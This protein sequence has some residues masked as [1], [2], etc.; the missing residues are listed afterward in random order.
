MRK[1]TEWMD[2]TWYPD[3]K[4]HWDDWLFRDRILKHLRPDSVVLDL[5]A[6][7]GIL[8][9]MNF[10]GIAARVF[11]I[12]LDA[13]VAD[14]PMLD[15][16]RM[17]DAAR[18]PYEADLF[19]AVWADNVLEHL[20]EPLTVFREVARVL[21]PGGVF[22]FKTPNRRHYVPLL[23]RLTPQRFHEYVNRL[24]GRAV[25]DTF[26][27]LYRANTRA[28]VLR[29]AGQSGLSVERV[30]LI[31]GRPE[32]LRIAWPAYLVGAAYE[33]LVNSRETFASFRILLVGVLRKTSN[34][35]RVIVASAAPL[36]ESR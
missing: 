36:E 8:P 23:A 13:R 33:R 11:G 14:N 27:T 6:G 29:F 24:R 35:P 4:S 2:R 25:V 22:L 7:A 15:E 3:F 30:E 17:A 16:A 10:R 20:A 31:E 34:D 26:P 12:D 5:G 28:D 19:D 21:K 1:L 9:Q 18:I 32:Y